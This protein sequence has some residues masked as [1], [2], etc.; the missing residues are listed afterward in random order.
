MDRPDASVIHRVQGETENECYRKIQE[1]HSLNYQVLGKRDVKIKKGLFFH[2]DGVEISYMLC[3]PSYRTQPSLNTQT[4]KSVDF[5]KERDKI[6]EQMNHKTNPQI[7]EVLKTVKEM[8]EQLSSSTNFVQEEHPTISKIEALLEENE[9]SASFIRKVIDRIRKNFPID[10]LD[11]FDTVQN[12]VVEWICES[13]SIQPPVYK[14]RPQIIVL[15]GPTGVGKTTTVAKLAARYAFG[16]LGNEAKKN[17]RIITIDWFRIGAKEQIEIYGD[18]MQVPVSKAQSCDDINNIIDMY[19]NDE[20]YIIIDTTGY[21]PKDYENIAK[22]KKILD[23]RNYS[24]ETYL[25]MTASTKLS[26]MKDIMQQYEIF[27]YDSVIITKFD[28]TSHIGNVVSGLSDK[29]KSLTYFTT[30]QKVPHYLEQA[31]VSHLLMKL[32]G[33]KFDS[34]SLCRKFDNFMK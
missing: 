26:D 32:S 6:L 10:T 21:S 22:M 31:S 14:S 8:Q 2:V 28:E 11:D 30:G 23:V 12:S 13:I 34:K 25:C 5:E 20:D 7:Q 4:S 29:G 16:K 17:V 18:T 9:F 27:G 15:V 33:F 1:V 24:V 19:R 3:R